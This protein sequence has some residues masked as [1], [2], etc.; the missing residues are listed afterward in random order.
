MHIKCSV[1]LSGM[2]LCM[3]VKTVK[4]LEETFYFGNIDEGII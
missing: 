2:W 3:L 4:V 1:Q